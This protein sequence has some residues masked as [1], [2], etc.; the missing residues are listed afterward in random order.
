MQA[1]DYA[2]P[3]FQAL[4]RLILVHGHWNHGR[5]ATL[6]LYSF[7]KNLCLVLT[8]FIF[9][10]YNGASGTVLYESWLYTCWNVVFTLF[11]VR[12]KPVLFCH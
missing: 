2:L 4:Q 6:I 11:P 10:F 7:Y 9:S 1:A 3:Q 8:I 5:I 12:S